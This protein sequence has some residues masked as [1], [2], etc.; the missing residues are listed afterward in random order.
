ML[1]ACTALPELH[2]QINRQ[3]Q[4]D[5]RQHPA[6]KKGYAKYDHAH[7]LVVPHRLLAGGAL[8]RITSGSAATGHFTTLIVKI[9]VWPP[10]KE[11]VASRQSS[12]SGRFAILTFAATGVPARFT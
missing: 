4:G 8:L 2:H 9:L 7:R 12:N 1:G 3:R 10:Y 5:W 6:A 11:D